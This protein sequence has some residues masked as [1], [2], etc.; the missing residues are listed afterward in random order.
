MAKGIRDK[1]AIIGM[2]CTTFGERW[3]MGGSELLVEAFKEAIADAGVDPQKDIQ[4]AWYGH[5]QGE[6]G[7]GGSGIPCARALRLPYIPVTRVEN[8]CAT[9]SEALRG[10]C[11]A[12]A[13]GAYDICLAIGV[14]KLKDTGFG[15]LPMS[16]GAPRGQ[17][18]MPNISAPGSFALLATRYFAKY[19][20]SPEEGKTMLAKVSAKSHFNGSLN[21]KAHLRRAVTVE[22]IMSAP[23]IAWPLGLFDCCGVSDGSAAAIVTTAELAKKFRQDP[24][25]VKALQICVT[26]G[27]ELEY[28]EWDGT[29]FATTTRAAVKAYEEAG[30][31]N[32]REEI[33]MAE[34]HDCFSIT[35]AV[36]M[37]DLQF[38]PRGKVKEDI[39]A[40]RFDLNGPQPVQP[41]GG[42]KSF[43]HPIGASGLRM[44]YEMYKQLQGRAQLPERQLKN[45]KFGLT[46]NLGGFPSANVNSLFIVGL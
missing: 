36:T 9:G 41:D 13:A 28:T 30:I 46:H 22:Q 43:G 38:S 21:P 26:S 40:G 24:V 15:G 8:M 33:S 27:E 17:L 34:V 4:A 3:D 44:M 31:K 11:Y 23:I 18:V 5:C 39:D 32:P 45:P 10:A 35:E 2:G 14:E 7:L 1:V 25:F 42:L 6:V 20:L 16:G 29:Y 19:G 37:E 12:V